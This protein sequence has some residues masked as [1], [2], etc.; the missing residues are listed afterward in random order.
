MRAQIRTGIMMCLVAVALL[1]AYS[2]EDAASATL[3]QHASESE[4][5]YDQESS[6]GRPVN[7]GAVWGAVRE[8]EAQTYARVRPR[9]F[10]IEIAMPQ[11]WHYMQSAPV[12][13]ANPPSSMTPGYDGYSYGPIYPYAP[14]YAGWWGLSP[15]LHRWSTISFSQHHRHH[16]GGHGGHHG[17]RGHHHR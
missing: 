8:F 7:W 3:D 17:A 16:V 15:W 10:S 1:L 9:Q 4:A 14:P 13:A 2:S 12:F 6:Q 11:P 5:A